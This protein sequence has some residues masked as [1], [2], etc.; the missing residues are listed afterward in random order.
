MPSPIDPTECLK[1]LKRLRES[2]GLTQSQL[3]KL[4]G[5]TDGS[6]VSNLENGRTDPGLSR[7]TH[8]LSAMGATL[9]DWAFF[10]EQETALDEAE[11]IEERRIEDDKLEGRVSALEALMDSRVGKIEDRLSDIEGR[12]EK[13]EARSGSRS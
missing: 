7:V 9:S 3:A 12:V 6:T 8:Y 13:G 10:A 1:A 5:Y 4:M 2:R 11:F